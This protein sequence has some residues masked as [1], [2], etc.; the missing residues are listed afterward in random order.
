MTKVNNAVCSRSTEDGCMQCPS[1]MSHLCSEL[2]FKPI[3]LSQVPSS[4]V[5]M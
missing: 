2:Y 4:D 1:I 3:T 5:E